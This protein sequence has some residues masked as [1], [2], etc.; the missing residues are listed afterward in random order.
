MLCCSS[1][2]VSAKQVKTRC[3]SVGASAGLVADVCAEV[4]EADGHIAGYIIGK[5]EGAGPK[6]LGISEAKAFT[7]SV[8]MSIYTYIYIIIHMICLYTLLPK[9]CPLHLLKHWDVASSYLFMHSCNS[10]TPSRVL[11]FQTSCYPFC[12]AICF[13]FLLLSWHGHVSAI[14]VAPEFRRTGVANRLMEYLEEDGSTETETHTDTGDTQMDSLTRRLFLDAT[15][16]NL[17]QPPFDRT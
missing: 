12:E 2:Q 9:H 4:A 7:K 16:H 5:V 8:T 15:W 10:V 3:Q 1:S 17:T 6:Q 13:A 14:S 11:W